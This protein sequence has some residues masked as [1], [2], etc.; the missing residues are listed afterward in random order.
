MTLCRCSR[1]A[2]SHGHSAA[3]SRRN[4][5]AIVPQNRHRDYDRQASSFD[6][7]AGLPRAACETIA[8]A[9]LRIAAIDPADVLLEI[10]AGT[11]Q[12]GCALCVQPLRYL[13]IDASRAM[14][15]QFDQ[16]CREGGHAAPIAVADAGRPWPVRDRGVRAVFGSRSLH[17]LPLRHVV[18]ETLRV[19]APRRSYMLI[20]RVERD[21]N[22]LRARLR[23]EMRNRLV[24]YGH[25]PREGHDRERELLDALIARGASPLQPHVAAT[26]PVR[27]NARELIAAWQVKS[28]LAGIDVSA[29]EKETVLYDLASW[30]Q[31]TLGS[32]D[33]F[34]TNEE[35]YMVAG[36]QLPGQS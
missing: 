24:N 34:E 29:A 18:D 5:I 33:A 20:G 8:R 14:L 16:R 15:E 23:R 9:L 22:G 28:G 7:R 6:R 4:R 35:K 30:A 11:G 25:A 13:G 31:E 27:R 12:I 3:I 2:P 26:W 32:L 17:L 36:V 19:A 10:G 21:R 1:P